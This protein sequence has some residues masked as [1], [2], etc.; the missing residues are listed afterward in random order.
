MRGNNVLQSTAVQSPQQRGCI[1]IVQVPIA[2]A[3]TLFQTVRIITG[4]KHPD[5]VVALKHQCMAP[6][7]D[8]FNMRRSAARIGKHAKPALTIAEYVLNRLSS[9]VRHGISLHLYL[10]NGKCQVRIDLGN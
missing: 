4:R 5:I 10:T 1:G 9:I 7:Q 3:N 8:R 6:P 2:S